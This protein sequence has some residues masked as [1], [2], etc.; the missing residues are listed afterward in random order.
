MR[1]SWLGLV[2]LTAAGGSAYG[3]ADE[4]PPALVVK[5]PA[6]KAC[7]AVAF[8]GDGARLA[9]AYEGD[10]TLILDAATGT[11]RTKV[12]TGAAGPDSLALSKD[13]GVLYVALPGRVKWWDLTKGTESGFVDKTAMGQPCLS[14][15]PVT[16]VMVVG[17]AGGETRVVDA[18][19]KQVMDS[20]NRHQL[21]TS[22]GVYS[23]DGS[24]VALEVRG[25]PTQLWR[26]EDWSLVGLLGQVGGVVFAPDGKTLYGG[27]KDAVVVYDLASAAK[28]DGTPPKP[29]ATWKGHVGAPTV[30]VAGDGALVASWVALSTTDPWVSLWDPVAGKRLKRWKADAKHVAMAV[31]QPG[32]RR[33]A[34]AGDGGLK[35]YDTKDVK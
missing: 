32:T 31:F 23:G 27:E 34:V 9:A 18:E 24:T 30:A 13:G 12:K 6:K 8:S 17:G 25:R 19:V 2:V 10:V 16:P 35:I 4:A 21:T 33:L 26:A 3:A 14:L 22:R 15:S 11:E 5:G 20:L 7:V 28:P 1:T 29:K